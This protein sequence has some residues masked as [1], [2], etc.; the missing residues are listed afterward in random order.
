MNEKQVD[1]IIPVYKTEEYLDECVKSVLRQDYPDIHIVLVDDGSPDSCPEKCDAYAAKY[2]NISVVHQK[3]MGLG[4]SRNSGMDA[5]CGTYIF[6]L[7][8]DD[9]LDGTGA[10]R[11]LVRCAEA[12]HADITIGSFRRFHDV[13]SSEPNHHQLHDGSY[14]KTIDFRF[15]GFT[16]GHLSYNWGKL[17]RRAFLEEHGLRCK[18]YPFT[19]DKAHNMACIAC[20]PV[21]AFV[22]DSV[23]QYRVNEDSVTFRYKENLMPVWISMAK[24]FLDFLKERDIKKKYGD[25]IAFHIF[26]GSLFLVKQELKAKKGLA[27][28]FSAADILKQYRKEPLVRCAMKALAKGR[29]VRKLQS[30]PLKWSIRTAAFLFSIHGDLLYAMSLALLHKLK[31][32]ERINRSRYH[33]AK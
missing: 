31:V 18:A 22:D 27:G 15:K 12:H 32:D 11:C 16:S 25:L 20:E 23:Y 24:D 14:T 28:I 6:F 3:N 9:K 2:P 33:Q 1:V 21:Y 7:D 13:T 29:F 26:Y 19:Q 4:L 30:I 5:S 10:I 17:Y 8:S